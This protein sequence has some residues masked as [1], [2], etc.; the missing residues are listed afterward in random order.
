MPSFNSDLSQ[1]AILSE[2]L[3]N[4]YKEKKI[5]F[6]RIF[7][8]DKQHQGIDLVIQHNSVDY[9]IDEKAQLHYLNK[10]L[11]TFTFELS[12]LKNNKLKEG[13]LF[14]NKKLT[15]YYF[16]ITGIFLKKGKSK[17]INADDID[18]L[19]ITSVNRVNL[20][21]YL[22]SIGLEKTKLLE[23]DLKLRE[24]NSFG[25]NIIPE[26]KPQSEGLIFFT[27]HLIEKPINLQLRLAYLIE[28]KIAKKFYYE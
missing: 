10:D 22:T 21:E 15:H 25:K 4:L 24:N 26:L 3:D 23:Y 6:Q 2:Y 14:D 8:L 20:I 17:L 18:K 7:D 1:E 13:W 19:K 5:D 9:F 11:P 28:N 27:E 16:L 12:Y